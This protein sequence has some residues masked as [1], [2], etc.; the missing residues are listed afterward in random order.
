MTYEEITP[1]LNKIVRLEFKNKKRKI[2]WLFID[3]Y[4]QISEEP[5]NEVHCVN[6]L[7]G[8]KLALLNFEI[9]MKSVERY[10]K[11]IQLAD[12]HKIRSSI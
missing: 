2:G 9:D 4:H 3:Y 5:L 12:I 10:S 7:D 6:V 1:H 11:K 8:K